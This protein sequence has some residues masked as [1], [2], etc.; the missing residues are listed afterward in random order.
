MIN[1]ISLLRAFLS[2]ADNADA[3]RDMAERNG[4][5]V[6][7]ADKRRL[8]SAEKWAMFQIKVAAAGGD[9]RVQID[10]DYMEINLS[11]SALTRS[12]LASHVTDYLTARGFE[13]S[14]NYNPCLYVSW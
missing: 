1:V 13:V 11:T 10:F 12:S 14:A 5:I 7:W 8:R 6:A 4:P 2:R 9:K 3:V